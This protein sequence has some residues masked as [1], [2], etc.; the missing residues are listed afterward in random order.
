MNIVIP[1]HIINALEMG[2]EVSREM[3]ELCAYMYVGL[4]AAYRYVIIVDVEHAL[5]YVI[6]VQDMRPLGCN[7]CNILTRY[8]ASRL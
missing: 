8:E 1:L 7:V 5:I 6:Y 4:Q 2:A 3:C